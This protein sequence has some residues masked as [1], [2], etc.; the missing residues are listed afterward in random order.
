M[1]ATQVY[2]MDMD[3]VMRLILALVQAH[4]TDRNAVSLIV[5]GW[6]IVTYKYVQAMVLVTLQIHVRVL[7]DILER[8]VHFQFVMD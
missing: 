5:M 4:T 1:K 3:P 6:C 7:Q 2:V 8:I